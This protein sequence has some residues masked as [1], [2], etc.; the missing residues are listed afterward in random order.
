MRVR[1]S[2]RSPVEH[3]MTVCK[4]PRLWSNWLEISR[5]FLTNKILD[6]R[7]SQ[8]RLRREHFPALKTGHT[9]L[10]RFL[11]GSWHNYVSMIGITRKFFIR[12]RTKNGSL[13]L[14]IYLPMKSSAEKASASHTC[15]C[16][17]AGTFSS[18]S[19]QE[20][21]LACKTIHNKK[22]K[23]QSPQVSFNKR[24]CRKSQQ[25]ARIRR[26]SNS[27]LPDNIGRYYQLSH[28]ASCWERDESKWTK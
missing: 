13:F 27:G 25:K 17:L 6:A 1:S 26:D 28:D 19:S 10:K 9:L 22:M 5:H 15:R 4:A 20:K 23:T 7:P 24:N 8:L 16:S 18:D 21:K 2:V 3:N 12:S 11:I 14:E